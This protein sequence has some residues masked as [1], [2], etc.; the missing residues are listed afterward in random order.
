MIFEVPTGVVADTR[1][2]RVSYLLGTT[3]MQVEGRT[4]TVL[5]LE[6]T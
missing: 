6:I 1:G 5:E 3:G 4:L 2:R